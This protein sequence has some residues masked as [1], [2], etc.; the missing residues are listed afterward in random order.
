MTNYSTAIMLFNED[1]RPIHTIYEPD[2]DQK[3]QPRYLFKSLD[4]TLKEGDYVVVP[5]DSRHKMTVVQVAEVDVEVDFESGV[6]INWIVS[7]VDTESAGE[8]AAY[9]KKCVD[10]MKAAEKR[11]QRE[12]IKSKL[13]GLQNGDADAIAKIAI[14][15]PVVAVE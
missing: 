5:T 2:T 11:H 9:E 6:H 12:E 3:K 13:I 15:A 4:K 8:V 1:I 10:L 14:A 7:K